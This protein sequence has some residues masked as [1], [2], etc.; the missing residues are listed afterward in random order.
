MRPVGVIPL[1]FSF[2]RCVGRF[3]LCGAGALSSSAAFSLGD[4]SKVV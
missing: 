2:A 1:A 3:I 4:V